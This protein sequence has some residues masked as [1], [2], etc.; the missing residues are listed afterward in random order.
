[1]QKF[2][3]INMATLSKALDFKGTS[4][5]REFWFF[6][7]FTWIVDVFASITDIFLPGNLTQNILSI[8]LFLPTLAVGIR[9]MHD[10]DHVGWWLL[11]PFLN[12]VFLIT[13]T[14]PNRWTPRFQ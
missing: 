5:R 14:K 3:D 4:T 11:F 2:I 8:L 10:T 1:M 12:I 6:I 13:P 7:L 9:R